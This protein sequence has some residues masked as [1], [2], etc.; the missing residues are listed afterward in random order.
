MVP[1]L[2]SYKNFLNISQN[3]FVTKILNDVSIFG[4]AIAKV[5]VNFKNL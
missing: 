2:G 1:K 4:Q 5:E 3:I